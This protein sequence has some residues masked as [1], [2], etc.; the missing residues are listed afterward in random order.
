MP[1]PLIIEAADAAD[2]ARRAAGLIADAVRA[3]PDARLQLATGNTPMA[4][5]AEL[6]DLHGRGELDT[7]E[8]RAIQLD[9]YLGLAAHGD[10]RSLG[11]WMRRSF[12]DPLE[13]P[14][15]H[16]TW[17]DVAG[18]PEAGCA[19]YAQAVRAA[20]G[21]DL[22]VLGL[23]PNGHLGFNEPPSPADAPT[24]VV[25]LTPESLISNAAYWGEGAVPRRAV[26][27]GM[28]LIMEARAVLLLV[29]GEHKRGILD[30]AL[31][32][33]PSEECPA[34]LLRLREGVT[35][36]ADRAALGR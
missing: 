21:L 15:A 27:A 32:E 14:E 12:T 22:T 33:R 31:R 2:L 29:S 16:I 30:R 8:L 1:D 7:S 3:R 10:P 23:G 20:G 4:T 19:R 28:D 17:L 36:V 18:D 35:I 34:S 13:I 26:T 6:V 11:D 5:Y 25:E 9:E 24:R